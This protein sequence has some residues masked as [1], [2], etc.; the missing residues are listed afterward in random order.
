VG[1]TLLADCDGRVHG[2]VQFHALGE[3][4][5][6]R[7]LVVAPQQRDSTRGAELMLA[8][9]A[10]LRAAGI[11]EWHLNVKGTERRQIELYERLGMRAKHRSA[12][13]RLPWRAVETMPGE[14][15]TALP[16]APAEDDDI[17]RSLGLLAGQI[18]MVRRRSGHV[19]V[20]LRDHDLCAVGFAA[21]DP[22]FPG[23]RVFRVAR[24]S[25]A[26]PLLAAL[27]PHAPHAQL[28]LVIDDDPALVALLLANGG[29]LALELLHYTGPVPAP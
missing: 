23:A 17:E 9:A 29:S 3:V 27:R 21:F 16:V 8:A 19:L 12:A 14:P 13:L 28:G 11:R 24:P 25:L 18:A 1:G 15:A 26:A 20:Q 22:E 2:Y 6:V 4:G 5:Y 7:H 10:A